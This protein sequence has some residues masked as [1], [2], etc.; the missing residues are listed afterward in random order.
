MTPTAKAGVG[1]EG[2]CDPP[3][4]CIMS[5]TQTLKT[6]AVTMEDMMPIPRVLVT[7][8]DVCLSRQSYPRR[9]TD[10]KP[11]ASENSSPTSLRR[12]HTFPKEATSRLP[13]PRLP[14]ETSPLRHNSISD[15]PAQAPLLPPTGASVRRFSRSINM[16]PR[17]TH[18]ETSSRSTSRSRSPM[19]SARVSSDLTSYR[20]PSAN[21]RSSRILIDD[22]IDP[23]MLVLHSIT[24]LCTDIIDMP[25]SSITSSPNACSDLV[26]KVQHIGHSWDE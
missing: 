8:G 18:S 12:Q 9:R 10:I 17:A 5:K 1:R 22:P 3:P 13:R 19:P 6:R 15:S 11:L 7:L 2:T 16:P 24:A 21:R 20:A 4:G 23:F 14:G 26:Q 25:L